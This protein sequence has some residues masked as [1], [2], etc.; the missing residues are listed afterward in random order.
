MNDNDKK[1]KIIITCNGNNGKQYDLA[2]C[3]AKALKEFRH[4]TM[5]G[6]DANLGYILPNHEWIDCGCIGHDVDFKITL[7]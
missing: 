4:H 5:Q 3:F 1:P 6:G 2:N 7:D